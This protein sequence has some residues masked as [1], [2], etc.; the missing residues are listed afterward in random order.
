MDRYFLSPSLMLAMLVL[1]LMPLETFTV[2]IPLLFPLY[3]ICSS[4]TPSEQY[5]YNWN[6]L[7]PDSSSSMAMSSP[8]VRQYPSSRN[9]CY[10]LK[11]WKLFTVCMHA[12]SLQLCPTLY[13]PVDCSRPGFSVRGIL[14]ASQ[15]QWLAMP[16]LQ[17]I[18]PTQQRIPHLFCLLA[19]AGGIFTT[20]TTWE[21]PEVVHRCSLKSTCVYRNKFICKIL[22]TRS[23]SPPLGSQKIYWFM[24]I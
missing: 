21:A 1:S 13:D 23:F 3:F 18:F 10:I 5:I 24:T 19:L 17:G 14:Q 4:Q 7:L 16:S 11:L 15:L 8:L 12:Q 2:K 22:S 9:C 6:P 20:S